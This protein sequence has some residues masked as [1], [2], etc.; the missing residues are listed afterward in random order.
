MER[1]YHPTARLTR[2]EMMKWILIFIYST[3][4]RDNEARLA[5]EFNTK[6]ACEA[7]FAETY[8]VADNSGLRHVCVEK[9]Q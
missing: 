9:G 4:Y 1:S 7:A 8:K 6:A 3:T 5:I 2:K